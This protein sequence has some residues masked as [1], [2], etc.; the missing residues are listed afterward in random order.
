MSCK[1]SFEGEIQLPSWRQTLFKIKKKKKKRKKKKKKKKEKGR[2]YFSLWKNELFGTVGHQCRITRTTTK[3]CI[4]SYHQGTQLQLPQGMQLELPPKDTTQANTNWPRDT[5]WAN[6][7]GYNSNT[8]WP[9]DTIRATTKGYNSSYHQLTKGHNSSYHQG[10]QLE[11]P[12]TDQGIQLE[13]PPRDT[14]RATTKEYNSIYHQGIQLELPPKD[15][16]LGTTTDTTQDTTNWLRDTTRYNHVSY[17]QATIKGH[18]WSHH[19]G[20]P[21]ELPV[22]QV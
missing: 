15:T 21:L 12:P 14:T 9:R 2:S 16:I 19:Q 22:C 3:G 20:T 13:L 8:N 7:R 4:A 1:W 18:N 10:I 6:T 17:Y 11:L 5:T